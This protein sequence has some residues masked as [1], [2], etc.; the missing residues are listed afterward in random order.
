MTARDRLREEV[1]KGNIW[2]DAHEVDQLID[3][4]IAEA[5]RD[6][7]NHD[8]VMAIL[9]RESRIQGRPIHELGIPSGPW[10]VVGEDSNCILGEVLDADTA[11]ELR[12]SRTPDKQGTVEI[13]IDDQAS[14]EF[15]SWLRKQIRT[16]NLPPR[17]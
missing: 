12:R 1:A 5:L 9:R 15:M 17:T 7:Q 11:A 3:D 13:T 8:A 16:H 14:P 2:V 4:V 10:R 6:P